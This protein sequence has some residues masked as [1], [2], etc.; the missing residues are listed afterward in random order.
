MKMFERERRGP[1]LFHGELHAVSAIEIKVV[2][3]VSLFKRQFSMQLDRLWQ[4]CLEQ[5]IWFRNTI[6]LYKLFFK[7]VPI[8]LQKIQKVADMQRVEAATGN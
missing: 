3:R 6:S 5:E 4:M 1:N 7:R 8:A 2:P